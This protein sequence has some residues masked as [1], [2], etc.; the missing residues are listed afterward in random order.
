MAVIASAQITLSAVVDVKAVYRYYLLQSSTL[1][2]PS[3]PTTTP[4]STPSGWSASEPTYTEGSTNSLYTVDGTVFSDNTW[5]WAD[6]QLSS[7]YEAAKAAYNKA[8]AANSTANAANSKLSYGTCST[9][10]ETAAKTVAITGFSLVK[11]ATVT[12]SFTNSNTAAN[13]T[14]N[15]NSTGAKNIRMNGA[16]LTVMDSWSA[17]ETVVFTYDG[18]YWAMQTAWKTMRASNGLTGTSARQA[19]VSVGYPDTDTNGF[20]RATMHAS[21]GTSSSEVNASHIAVRSSARRQ[22]GSLIEDAYSTVGYNY[23]NIRA[24]ATPVDAQGATGTAT[25]SGVYVC[26]DYINIMSGSVRV[27]GE[28]LEL[29]GGTPTLEETMIN[30]TYGVRAWKNSMGVITLTTQ[31]WQQIPA[32]AKWTTV[33]FGTMPE[34]WRPPDLLQQPVLIAGL[35]HVLQV[36]A[37]GTVQLVRTNAQNGAADLWFTFTYVCA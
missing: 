27:N 30:S 32:G 8:V 6:V 11:G 34:G 12:V 33:V 29:G 24:T 25:T 22:E 20:M 19:S 9:A 7:S 37:D 18:S 17:G 31:D 14:L 26:P 23:V 36:L 1:T 10:A 15:V 28:E 13:P 21:A 5:A 4:A 3:K 35:Q 16:N 2:K